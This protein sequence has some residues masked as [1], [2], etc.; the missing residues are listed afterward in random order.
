MT[1]VARTFVSVPQRS[2]AETW[3][4]IVDLI[5]PSSGSVV[6]KELLAIAGTG[7][8]CIADEALAGDP[9]V[10]YGSWASVACL[11]VVQ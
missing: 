6:R 2:A 9:I 7:T 10:V 1:V 11:R 8:S 3:N 4:A 5:A